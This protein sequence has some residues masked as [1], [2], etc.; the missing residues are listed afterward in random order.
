MRDVEALVETVRGTTVLHAVPALM[1]RV[2][3][4]ARR[5]GGLPRL[6]ML[7]VGG[8]TVPPDLLEEMREV[9]PAARTHVL[10]GPT[11]ATIIC[12]TY[13]VPAEGRLEGHPLGTPLPGVRLR[14]RGARGA[15]APLGVPGELWI[16]G[17]GVAR[18][19]LG[20]P[21]LTADRFVEADGEPAYRTGDRARWRADGVLE[22][23]GRTDEQVKVRG[24]RVEPGEVEAALRA[25]AGVREAVVV[26]REDA[27][28]ERRLVAYVVPEAAAGPAADAEGVREQVGG[29]ETLFDDTYG[30]G[31]D[32]AAEDPTLNLVGWNSSYTGEPIPV[33][34]MREWVERTVERIL[35]LEPRRVLEIG[36]G[37]GLLLFRV[38]PHAELYHGTDFSAAALEHVRRHARGLP[39]VRLSRRPADR[40]DGLG[41]EGFDTVVVNSV[42][43]Y[44]PDVDYLLRVLEG[45]AAV[46]RPGG[47]VFVGDVRSLPLLPAF[48]AS[49]ELF[50]APGELAV[51]H[52]RA[53]VRRGV[54]EEQE[55][56]VD[57][58]FWEALRAR[59]PRVGRVEMQVKRAAHDNEVSRFRYDV[60]LHLDAPAPPAAPACGWSGAG[61]LDGVRGRLE[62]SPAA[63]AVTGVPGARVAADLHALAL[64]ARPGAAETVAELRRALGDEAEGVDPEAFWALG[65]ALGRAVEVRPGAAGSVD[66]LFGPAGGGAAAFPTVAAEALPWEAYANDPRFGRRVRALVPAL[67]AALGERLPEYMVPAAFLVLEALPVTPNGKVDRAALPAPDPGR[68]AAA[69]EYVAPRT[70]AEERVAAV[71]TE[72]LGIERVGVADDF[73]ALGGHSLLAT[74][75]ASRLREALGVEVPLRTIFEAP[76]V[77]GLA[78]RLEGAAPGSAAAGPPPIVRVP[79]DPARPL[80]L[81]FAQQRLWFIEQLEPGNPAY[82]VP[83]VLR[84]RGTLDVRAL[85]RALGELVRRHEALRTVF[86][87]HGGEAVQR[88]LPPRPWVLPAADV[89]ALPAGARGAEAMRRAREEALRPFD[90]ARGPLL[91]TLLVRAD[92]EEWLLLLVLHHAVSDA[93]SVGVLFRELSALY[94]AFAAGAPSPL[95]EPGV[96]YAD[97][98]VWQREWLSGTA[99]DAQLAWW[100][101]RLEGAPPVLDLPL[102]RPR[103]PRPTGRGATAFRL[104]PPER[105][106]ALRAL[107]RR[108]GA[109][110]YM[111]LLAGW[112][113]LLARWA[114]QDDVVVG[115]PIAGRG[116]REVEGTVGFFVNTLALRADLSDDPAFAALLARV[117]EDT[118][119]AHAHQDLPF[120]RL[121]EALRV[122]RSLAYTPLFQVMFSLEESAGTVPALAGVEVEEVDPGLEVVEFDLVLRAQERAEGLGLLVHYRA[123]LFDAA[124]VERM[125]DAFALLLGAVPAGAGRRVLELPLVGDEELRRVERWSA[126]PLLPRAVHTPVHRLFAAQA[127]RTPDAEA[128]AC[129]GERLTYAELDRRANRLANHL[130]R[131]GVGPETRVGVCLERTPELVAALLGVLKAGGAYVPLDPAY[132]RERLGWMVAD[133]EARLVLTSAALA[134]RLPDGVVAVPVD[135]LREEI[136]AGSD[137]EPE[138]QV[139]PDNL[140]HVIF[141]SGSTGRPK[142]VMIRHGAVAVLLHWLRGAVTDEERA[143]VLFSTSISFDVSVAEVFGTLCWGGRLVMV[144][145]ALELAAA[146]EPVVHASMVPTAAAELLR[147]GAVPA[148][149]KTLNLGGEPLPDD[150]A[151]ALYA[152][153]TVDR[154][155]NLYGPT[156]DT[157]YSTYSLVGRGGAQVLVGRPVA[158]TRAR[159]LDAELGPVPVGVVGELYLA[160]DKLARGYA[161]RPDLT[162]E[163]F[164]PDPFGPPGSRMYR[165]MDRVRWRADGELEYFGRTDFQVKVR[166]FRIELGEIETALREHPAVRDAVALVREDAPGDRRLV[167]YLVAAGG[168]DLAEV[169]DRLRTRLPEYMVPAVL[170]VLEKLPLTPSGK[171]DRRA[172]PAPEAP[173]A[174][175]GYVA[176]RTAG[177]EALAAIW[178]EVLGVE[179]VGVH[180][181]FFDLGGHSLL[182]M[183]LVARARAGLGVEI[184][185]S[186]VFEAPT[187]AELAARVDRERGTAAG[188]SLPRL[189][190]ADRGGAARLPL[191]FA[192]ERLWFLHRL[193]P[194]S[195]AY[196]VPASLRLRG[197]LD[198]GALRRALAALVER[199]ESLRTV[200][201]V[202]G[203]SRHRPSSPRAPSPSPWTTCAASR[204]ASARPRRC[205]GRVMS[206]RPGSTWSAARSSAPRC[207]GCAPTTTCSPWRCTTWSRTGGAWASCSATSRRCTGPSRGG[208][209][210]PSPLPPCSTP[211]T[212]CG[213]ASGSAATCSTRSS[214]SGAGNCGEPRLSWSSRP[215]A[216]APRHRAGAGGSTPWSS[217]R[218]WPRSCARSP[219]A[220]GPRSSPRPWRGSRRSSPAGPA[221][222]TC[223]WGRRSPAGAGRSWRS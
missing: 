159:V 122:E 196:N 69:A 87:E 194:D 103:P 3:E 7:L 150:L 105:A 192:Q 184:P 14:V 136:G 223:W 86:A 168:L 155:G 37:T 28:G 218:S 213:S 18:G 176:P 217:R 183:R 45:A 197:P 44:F 73:F 20:R 30:A 29:W 100:R 97:Y 72:V 135:A 220:R 195:V 17:G 40:L 189:A 143:S 144:E 1:R 95:A 145:N 11:E 25:Q 166:G 185:V 107:A 33:D 175:V 70:P 171:L 15:E 111:V 208:S 118:L 222:T 132:P 202:A 205:A 125:L 137:A 19:Y 22:F 81:S 121:V 56:A 170:V 62:S 12:A 149:V 77:E 110:L 54:A 102:D 48:H 93:W 115:T 200:F 63:L 158:N 172:L 114:A 212:P 156:E 162:A 96:Q 152:L 65:E 147:M 84:L 117:R 174:G 4:T 157:T 133:A 34:E 43:Q 151:R 120:E 50:R 108:E 148:G 35:A 64:L 209:R 83:S 179:R 67:R 47:R 99:L 153:G 112:D 27:P 78:A 74:Q 85:E 134:G 181:G 98:T 2:V 9:F 104:L 91:R 59:V 180:D 203:G 206:P 23:L 191:S 51:E 119:G 16:S 146:G 129:R 161:S 173:V 113:A 80:P 140:S 139:E 182:A 164:L 68:G 26:A 142:G 131:L 57:P 92:A 124:T 216:R 219:G 61:G 221:R 88:V 75:V 178:A 187:V 90:L 76:T 8:D 130:R 101:E 13:A 138:V 39:G 24:F 154:V 106:G 215:T 127:A 58:A 32:A 201:P 79:R 10:Y 41:G 160:G 38:A 207:C 60:V 126:G 214:A 169:R 177:E 204:R 46:V 53:R 82:N 210:P 167:A 165:V 42:A 31:G 36:C 211:T 71:W 49:V 5:A 190:P 52:L 123:D 141:T 186:A 66:V 193:A 163:R 89:S 198:A 6:R 94:G 109:T 21:G 128:V 55:L 116:R 199:H 188:P